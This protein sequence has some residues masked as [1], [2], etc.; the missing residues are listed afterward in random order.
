MK[1][2]LIVLLFIVGTG[3]DYKISAQNY[4]PAS[5]PD[6][7]YI[8]AYANQHN[9]L[10]FAWSVDGKDW[11]P[12]G[13]DHSFLRSDYGPWGSAKRMYN[14]FL[15]KDKDGLWHCVWQLNDRDGIFAHAASEDLVF[16]RRQSYPIVKNDGNLLMPEVYSAP[17]GYG[18]RWNDN[19][20]NR[21]YVTTT[22]FKNY[23]QTRP[24]TG[25]ENNGRVKAN[26]AGKEETGTVHKVDW[27]VIEGIIKAQQLAAYKYTS[28]SE[29]TQGDDRRFAGLKPVDVTVRIDGSRSKPISDMLIGVFFEDINYAADGGIYAE[30]VQNRDFEYNPA[31]RRGDQNWNATTAWSVSGDADLAIS[32]ADP[33]HPNNSHYARLAVRNQ[34]AGLRN[35][36]FD[37]IVLNEGDKYDFSIFARSPER[38]TGKMLVRLV[39][40]NGEVYGQAE[41]K[42]VSSRWGQYTAT[43]T[44]KGSADKAILEIVP[45]MSGEV[46]MDMISL[47]PQKTF[48]GR[49][50][51]LRADLAQ[52]IADMKPRFVRFPGGCVAHG[53]GLENMYRWQNTIGKLEE[54]KPQGNLWGYHQSAG[55]GYYEYFL[56]CEDIGAQPLPVIPAGVPCQNSGHS[57]TGA[58][59]QGGIPMEDMDE[60][61]QEIFD[62]IEWANGDAKTTWGR[63]RAEAGHPKPFNL[64]Y[65]GV[66]N[67]DLITDIFEERFKMIYD[68]VKEKH[69]EI[70]VIGTV[71]PTFEGTDYVEGW[72]VASKLG[73]PIVDEHYYQSPGWF[74]N[75]Q[76]YYDKYDRSKPKVYL[77]EYAA[78]LPGRPNNVETALAEALH[79]INV[80]RNADVVVMTSYAPLLAKEGRT[81]WHPDLI[82]FNNREVKPTVGYHVQKIF[83]NNAGQEYIS[84]RNVYDSQRD[85]VTKR[86]AT[87]VVRDR[88]TGDIIIKMVNLLPVAVNASFETKDI[89]I[90]QGEARRIRLT[91][92][93]GD[94]TAKPQEGTV[95]AGPQFMEELPPY[96]FTLIRITAH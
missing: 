3:T 92:T 87:S 37:G 81:Q 51:G 11:H 42:P 35:S 13:P 17:A 52:T 66:G 8:F 21:Y 19:S 29:T 6:Q 4:Y 58:G 23:S 72:Q 14:P 96:S 27:A 49:K 82:Y 39:G 62:L 22:D 57:H 15:F 54:R 48:K 12:V 43:I 84:S 33:I 9:G 45:V 24:Y 26:I 88:E 90:P 38:K 78:H 34:G 40:E 5:S 75:N 55:L 41:T 60:Y 94:L 80:E 50:N 32:D 77:G 10:F 59:Q 56:F 70:T 69:P 73:V 79:L 68:A 95:I 28:I 53:S 71:G 74:I 30:L 31:E 63:K 86:I 36:G 83:G 65:L 61:I 44:A 18:I 64:K 93:P 1:K 76:D 67:E 25:M 2:L 85:A 16:W 7:G 89:Q 20:G 46:Q 47:F 91:G